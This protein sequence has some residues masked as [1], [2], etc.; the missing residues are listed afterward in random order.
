MFAM[1]TIQSHW[2]QAFYF[3]KLFIQKIEFPLLMSISLIKN[4]TKD[5]LI[6]FK[7]KTYIILLIIREIQY[8][9]K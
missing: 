2:S 7:Q 4:K 8:K 1:D 3:F 9:L 6:Y 5:F